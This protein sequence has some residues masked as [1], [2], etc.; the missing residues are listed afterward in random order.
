MQAVQHVVKHR[1]GKPSHAPPNSVQVGKRKSCFHC[2]SEAYVALFRCHIWINSLLLLKV[3]LC[4]LLLTWP[5]LTTKCRYVRTVVTSRALLPMMHCTDFAMFLKNE[6][7]CLRCSRS[8]WPS[9]LLAGQGSKMIWMILS[10]MDVT[11]LRMTKHF[12]WFDSA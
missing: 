3:L 8:W 12:K 5:M 1:R 11:C 9:S 10:S 6:L 7:Q 4:S 2:G